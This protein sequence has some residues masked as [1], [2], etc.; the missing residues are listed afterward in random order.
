MKLKT[1]IQ[2]LLSFYLVGHKIR[3][4][5]HYINEIKVGTYFNSGKDSS[6]YNDDKI[7][8]RIVERP[9]KVNSLSIHDKMH[10][11]GFD[12]FCEGLKEPLF[13]NFTTNFEIEEFKTKTME[14]FIENT[15]RDYDMDVET[16]R[17]FY[18]RHYEEGLFYE[19]L[20]EYI[21]QR[22]RTA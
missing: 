15:A 1:N 21:E 11:A 6:P 20:E 2:D 18:E 10:G 7:N 22:R 12:L 9:V 17:K 3:I 8:T 4:Y 13:I 19:K 16:V 14:S 5:E